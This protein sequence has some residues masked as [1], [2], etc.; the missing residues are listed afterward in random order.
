M[1]IIPIILGHAEQ[2]SAGWAWLA[3]VGKVLL[4]AAIAFGTTWWFNSRAARDRKLAL[5]YA[6]LLRAQS[7]AESIIELDRIMAHNKKV[8]DYLSGASESSTSALP[9][10]FDWD[11]RCVFDPEGLA[12]LA[13]TGRFVRIAELQELARLH[14]ILVIMTADYAVR[15]ERLTARI[16]MHE[17]D[18]LSGDKKDQLLAASQKDLEREG[19]VVFDLLKQIVEKASSGS[20]FAK[21][22]MTTLGPEIRAA[23][24]DERFRMTIK[25]Q[26]TSVV[27]QG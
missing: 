12:I 13:V 8:L 14:D 23:L 6:L 7:A 3:D 9:S 1:T 18:V 2:G 15:F 16:R 27:E 22:V 10:G 21:R 20:V 24:G 26:D 25:Y 19:T 5:G 11:D 17:A 4:G